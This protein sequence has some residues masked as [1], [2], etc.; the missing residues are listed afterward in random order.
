MKTTRLEEKYTLENVTKDYELW[1]DQDPVRPHL[2]VAFKTTQGRGVF[3][4]KTSDGIYKAF[5]CWAR[6][7]LVPTSEGELCNMTT[8]CG[9]IIV[10]YTVWSYERGAGREIIKQVVNCI[11]T[12]GTADRVVTL[13]PPTEMAERF[14]LRNNAR[15]V[16]SNSDTVNFEYDL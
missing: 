16:G 1:H 2:N 12:T 13:S 14:H 11:R 3:G 4:L 8:Q 15:L 7:S 9:R 6:T 10:P 5:L